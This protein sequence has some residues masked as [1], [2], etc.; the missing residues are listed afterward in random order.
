MKYIFHKP[1]I[2]IIRLYQSLLSPFFGP[3]C[4]HLPTC[5]EYAIEAIQEW[6]LIHGFWLSIKRISRCNPWG[7]DGYDPVPISKNKP[8]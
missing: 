5:S 3:H 7:T 6:G 4:R 2:L 1:V 8:N